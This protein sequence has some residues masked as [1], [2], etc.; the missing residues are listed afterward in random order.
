MR[1][2]AS[3]FFGFLPPFFQVLTLIAIVI[4]VAIILFKL[5]ALI[6]DAIPFL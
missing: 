4:L 3:L 1:N 5:V 2:F 6:L